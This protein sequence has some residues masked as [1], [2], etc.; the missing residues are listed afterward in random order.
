MD[1]HQRHLPQLIAAALLLL[2]S[3]ARAS[4]SEFWQEAVAKP[5][6]AVSLGITLPNPLE[7][8][9][10]LFHGPRWRSFAHGSISP[11]P[12]GSAGV[13]LSTELEVGGAFH[14]TDDLHESP[15][16]AWASV[17]FQ[18]LNVNTTIRL[19]SLASNLSNPAGSIGIV[20]FYVGAGL[21]WTWYRAQGLSWGFDLGL[22]V[23]VVGWGGI[24]TSQ[25]A[26]LG[27]SSATSFGHYATI[28]YPVITLVRVS[29]VF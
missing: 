15:F 28:V 3:P 17:G 9:I 25:S 11:I 10:S 16:Y 19:G 13:F 4:F 5:E 1:R 7:L 21:G 29:K 14:L 22:R 6:K 2:A 18:S 8:G 24:S 20:Q 26:S 23:P 12:L 27:T